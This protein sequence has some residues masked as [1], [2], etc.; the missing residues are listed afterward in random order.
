M[1]SSISSVSN[2]SEKRSEYPS[3]G[4][5]VGVGVGDG[6]GVGVGV[7]VGD[8]V[9][10]GESVGMAVAVAVKPCILAGE[11]ALAQP[12]QASRKA[13][14]KKEAP[15]YPYRIV[16]ISHRLISFYMKIDAI[17]I[18]FV[19]ITSLILRGFRTKNQKKA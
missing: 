8:G 2:S 15:I 11:E 12:R 18:L 1:V 16:L 5:G 9:G 4:P 19:W 7:G 14:I 13:M 17:T 10:V 6:V 3:G